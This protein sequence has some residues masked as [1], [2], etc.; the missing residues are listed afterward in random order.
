MNIYFPNA[1]KYGPEKLR[2]CALFTQCEKFL[3]AAVS[4]ILNP[5]GYFI[6]NNVL[7]YTTQPTSVFRT[8]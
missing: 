3:L 6:S 8:Y 1:E 2:I 7:R 5:T 4:Q